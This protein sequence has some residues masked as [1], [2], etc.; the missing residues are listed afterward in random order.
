MRCDAMNRFDCTKD[1]RRFSALYEVVR[2]QHHDGPQMLCYSSHL[3]A[4]KTISMRQLTTPT[5][6]VGEINLAASA[7]S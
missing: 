2:L 7:I 1:Q 6:E 3:K 5:N 4:R